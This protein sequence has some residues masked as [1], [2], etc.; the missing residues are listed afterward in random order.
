MPN[1]QYWLI[2]FEIHIALA[3]VLLFVDFISFSILLPMLLVKLKHK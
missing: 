2:H 3:K 1:Y